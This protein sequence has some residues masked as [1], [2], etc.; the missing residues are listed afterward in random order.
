MVSRSDVLLLGL[1]SSVAGSLIG[2]L[3]FGIG[4]AEMLSGVHFGIVP[5]VLAAPVSGAAGYLMARRL[6]KQL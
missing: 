3:T 4:L 1:V 2:G 6:A 5:M